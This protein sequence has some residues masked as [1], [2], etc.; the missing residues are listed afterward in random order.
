MAELETCQQGSVGG[1]VKATHTLD[2]I[3]VFS[4]VFGLCCLSFSLLPCALLFPLHLQ[5]LPFGFHVTCVHMCYPQRPIL[6][7]PGVSKTPR[8]LPM[9]PFLIF[10]LCLSV[11][12]SGS[13][14]LLFSR[15]L[16]S[17]FAPVLDPG[18]TQPWFISS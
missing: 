15:T 3:T 5:E 4:N 9:V 11:A 6:S 7:L 8:P 10:V 16:L 18:H 17:S 12:S 1:L 14:K 2:F 13:Q